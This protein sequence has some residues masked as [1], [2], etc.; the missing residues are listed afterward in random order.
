MNQEEFKQYLDKENYTYKQDGKWLIVNHQDNISIT[1]YNLESLPEYISFQNKGDVRISF[2]DNLKSLPK[3]ITFQ[4]R[5]NVRISYNNNLKNLPEYISFQNQGDVSI[6]YNSNL[7][8]LP[9]YISFQ[10]QGYVFILRNKNLISLPKNIYFDKNV[11]KISLNEN[12]KLKLNYYG[13]YFCKINNIRYNI[14]NHLSN[15]LIFEKIC[16][17][18]QNFN[19]IPYQTPYICLTKVL[20]NNENKEFV[21]INLPK[22]FLSLS[23]WI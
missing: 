17:N 15:K 18:S 21:N 19:N 12:P 8:S 13:N 3:N 6:S 1:R 10:N 20:K 23:S 5:G 22:N 4:N 2:N 9:E 11:K 7:K 14:F 16:I